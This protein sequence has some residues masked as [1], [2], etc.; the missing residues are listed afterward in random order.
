M[1]ITKNPTAADAEK[2]YTVARAFYWL[3]EVAGVGT[4]LQ[5]TNADAAPLLAANKLTPGEPVAIEP[6]DAEQ[7][8]AEQLAA[9]Q[10]AADLAAA[11]KAAAKKAKA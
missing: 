7:L 4:V 6:A 9:E 1:A 3:G 5:L 10:V 2:A 11:D 8:A